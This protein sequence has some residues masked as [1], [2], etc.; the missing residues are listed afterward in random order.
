MGEPGR[1][2]AF[3]GWW[4][5]LPTGWRVNAGLYAL[6]G[7]SLVAL[8][9]QM[10]VGGDSGPRR[11]EVAA[12]RREPPRSTTTRVAPSTSV[13]PSTV[14]A[15]T[16]TP[17]PTAGRSGPAP[18][19]AAR[20]GG[21]AKGGGGGG[22][23]APP[24]SFNPTPTS[25][26]CQN[27]VDPACGEF[28]W[29]PPPGPNAGLTISVTYSPQAPRAGDTVTF[30]LRVTDPDH[31][32]TGN[33]TRVE[34]GDGAVEP[35]LPCNPDPPCNDAHGPWRPPAPTR[36]ERTFTFSHE[37]R[38]PGDFRASF[39]FHTDLDHCRNPYGSAGVE[40]VTVNV[41]PVATGSGQG[42]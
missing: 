8:L 26:I 5:D 17:P 13:P 40:S 39:E 42:T 23:G 10:V 9:T 18:T 22:G 29:E 34:Y 11:V 3:L 37:Y 6:A 12:G 35:G 27:S 41:A 32:I 1:I 14:A 30:T 4:R 2:E 19:S 20:G 7:L 33:C 24:V 28:R 38:S 21:G 36:G 25:L 15:V 31:L 16:T